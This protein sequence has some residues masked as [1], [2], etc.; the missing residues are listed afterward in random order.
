MTVHRGINGE[1]G[2]E[3]AVSPTYEFEV[4]GETNCFD[5][6]QDELDRRWQLAGQ[7]VNAHWADSDNVLAYPNVK[8][9]S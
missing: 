6:A 1:H 7:P 9:I 8:P 3:L 2:E 4:P 5:A